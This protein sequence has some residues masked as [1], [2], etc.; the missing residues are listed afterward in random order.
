[1]IAAAAFIVQILRTVEYGMRMDRMLD[2]VV[3]C[4]EL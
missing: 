4:A 2:G 3:A 1:M